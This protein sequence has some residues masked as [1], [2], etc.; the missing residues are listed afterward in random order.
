MI[1]KKKDPLAEPRRPRAAGRMSVLGIFA[2]VG[3]L[4]LLT[5]AGCGITV[6]PGG[7]E[8]AF[9]QG[10]NLW[11]LQPDGSNARALATGGIVS[12]AWS[13]DHHQ[14]LYRLLLGGNDAFAPPTPTSAVPDAAGAIAVIGIN[15]GTPLVLSR[16]D[17]S[18]ARG[19][20]WWNPGG[21]RLLYREDFQISP[22]ASAFVVSQSD[23]PV[24][25]ASKPVLDA[26]SLPVLSSDGHEVA[27]LDTSGDLLLGT[28]GSTGAVVARGGVLTLPGTNRPAHLLWQPGHNELLYPTAAPAGG[29]RLVLVGLG[30][31]VRW[32]LSVPDLIDAAFSPDG[33]RLL[34]R[35]ASQFEVFQVGGSTA[36]F[37]WSDSDPYAQPWWAPDGNRMLILDKSSVKL[38]NVAK[39]AETAL[40]TA[41]STSAPSPPARQWWHPATSDPWSADGGR[42]VLAASAGDT[43][44]G[45]RFPAPSGSSR[46]LY[47]V[48]L[49]RG[50]AAG[51][52]LLIDSGDDAAPA[53]SYAD[54]STTFLVGA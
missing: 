20:A 33:S 52:P 15:G 4:L 12:I 24:G 48:S 40:G 23:Q 34:V 6:H 2:L 49:P 53:W 14:V 17:G 8:I 11:G 36:L 9:L 43:W 29:T 32:S 7:D 45:K 27:I 18:V 39:H 16:S 22:S 26:A 3:C 28:P 30:G 21:N 10:G 44:L 46:G 1:D 35:T 41:A 38:V 47:V 5:L 19:D 37:S 31:Q 25:I 13:P 42:I 50:G 51:S 54:P